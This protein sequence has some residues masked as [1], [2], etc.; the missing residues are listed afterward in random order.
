M[1]ARIFKSLRK[2]RN[3]RLFFTG[4]VVSL[5]GTW[6]Q[7]IALAWFVVELTDSPLAVG[8]LAFCRFLPFM[9][10]GL[11]A[12]V[13]ADRIDNRK[14][15][16]GTQAAQMVV[17][18]ALTALAFSGWEN[19]PAVYVLA[20]LGGSALVLDAPGRQ[21]LTFQM[22]GR[23]E[24]PNAVALNTGLFNGARIIG[25]A[26]AG[27]IIG[28]GGTGVCFLINSITFLAVLTALAL[29]REDELFKVER[30]PR[31]RA[32]AAIAE[33]LRYAWGNADIRLALTVLAIASTVGF[34]FHVIIPVLARDTLDAGP[35]VFGIL[36]AFFGG[37]ALL[38][39]LIQAARSKASWKGL[40]LGATGFSTGLLVLAPVTTVWL[41][42]VILFAVGVCFHALGLEHE[43][44]P[45]AARAGSAARACHEPLHVRVRRPRADRR[46]LR[47]LAD[48]RRRHRAR[49]RRRRCGLARR[50]RPRVGQAHGRSCAPAASAEPLL[51][52]AGDRP[53]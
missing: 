32:G 53:A 47:R 19:V 12:G 52:E 9:L 20:F 31:K 4:Q 40:L 29:M 37:G 25:P 27:V 30:D 33:G 44:D 48:G 39:A 41:A 7:N 43:R 10:F 42:C 17:S 28:L 18:V 8:G 49:A 6:M 22:V 5:A 11:Y 36:S 15:V 26:I 24:L 35:E 2:H 14:L 3:Y 46:P 1:T 50:R 34:N 45:P 13:I 51:V 16:M 23:D 38:G 21:S